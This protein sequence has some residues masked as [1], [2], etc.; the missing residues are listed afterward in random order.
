MNKDKCIILQ[1]DMEL[2]MMCAEYFFDLE[3][4]AH[5]QQIMAALV[6]S[7]CDRVSRLR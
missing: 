7:Y 2:E 3:E 6:G 1:N 5:E 4:G